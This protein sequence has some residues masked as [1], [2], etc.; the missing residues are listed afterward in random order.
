M[1]RRRYL[2]TEISL[3]TRV[4]RLAV[5]CGDFAAL[6]Y[7]WMIPH[8]ADDGSL[9]DDPESLLLRVMPGRRD[10]TVEEVAAALQAMHDLG[11]VVWDAERR[12]IRFPAARSHAERSR[13]GGATP[14]DT[15][16]I[17]PDL[18]RSSAGAPR[19]LRRGSNRREEAGAGG[20]DGMG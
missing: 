18:R 17:P 5:R 15:S 19:G 2:S 14:E 12:E 4:N 11:L 7:T 3:D 13:R 10:R 9:H 1:S 8:A 20:E 16:G 6:L